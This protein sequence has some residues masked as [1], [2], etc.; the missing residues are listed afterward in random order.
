MEGQVGGQTPAAGLEGVGP[1][2]LKGPVVHSRLRVSLSKPFVLEFRVMP[3]SSLP[4]PLSLH[5]VLFMGPP[6]LVF[7]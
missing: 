3:W 5:R 7:H 2:A 4:S 1:T 6:A